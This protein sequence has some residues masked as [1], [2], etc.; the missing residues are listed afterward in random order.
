MVAAQ[1]ENKKE[2]YFL[3]ANHQIKILEK[4][5]SDAATR[6]LTG[7]GC[8]PMAVFS[9]VTVLSPITVVQAV[10]ASAI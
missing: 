6:R 4:C 2:L 7:E 10:S 8:C 5:G 1:K 3:Q 9:A